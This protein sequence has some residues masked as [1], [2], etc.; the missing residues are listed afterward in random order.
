MRLQAVWFHG[1][2]GGR[3]LGSGRQLTPPTNRWPPWGEGGGGLG[4]AM[5]GV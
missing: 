1:G 5:G 2:G 4:G 3:L